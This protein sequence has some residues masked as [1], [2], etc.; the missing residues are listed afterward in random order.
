MGAGVH[1]RSVRR[2]VAYDGSS[3]AL[4][5]L[6]RAAGLHHKNDEMGV[7]CVAEF[8]HEASRH[9]KDACRR[10]LALGIEATPIAA[11]GDPGRTICI[12]ADRHAY[13]IIVVG[14]RNLTDQGFLLL[15]S[16]A[17]R[18]VAGAPSDVLVVA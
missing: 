8:A 18:V 4:R 10:L 1:R 3:S 14:R 16:V 9:L 11:D 7:V 12:T 5:A 13:D 17:Q 6:H 2:L 15:G